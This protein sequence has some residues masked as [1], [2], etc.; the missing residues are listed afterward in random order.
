MKKV[1]LYLGKF[2]AKKF[3]DAQAICLSTLTD[4]KE[5]KIVTD[6]YHSKSLIWN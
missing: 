1:S 6:L 4:N 5:I 2:V 3:L